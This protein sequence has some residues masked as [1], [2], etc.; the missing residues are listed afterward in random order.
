MSA[1]IIKYLVA[2]AVIALMIW[3]GSHL[4]FKPLNV[5]APLKGEA[6]HNPYYAAIKL[7]EELDA[8]ASW[9][10]VFVAPASDS[11]IVLS[12]WSWTMSRPRR[13]R[14]ERW[15]ESGGRLV[16]DDSLVSDEQTFEKWSGISELQKDKVESETE[17]EPASNDNSLASRFLNRKCSRLSEDVT[18]REFRVCDVNP[19]RSLTSSRK[20]LWALRAGN[21]IHALRTRVG[22]GSVTVLNASPFRFRDLFLGDHAQLLVAATQL[23]S[24]DEVMFLTEQDQASLL[25][26]VL[27]YGTPVVLLFALAIALA[28]WRVSARLGPLVAPLDAARRSLAEQ[29]RG[30]GQFAVRFGGG[31]ALHAATVRALRDAALRYFPAYD[32]LSSVDRVAALAKATGVPG[33]DLAPALN[34]QGLRGAAELRTAIAVLETTR[35]RILKKNKGSRNGN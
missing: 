24:G 19:A 29:I 30:T 9:E 33:D 8:E 18:H 28:I 14:M 34:V 10:R 4:R 16:V 27:R 11:V 13:E 22:V 31:A 20:I 15:V 6:A 12:D 17:D 5:D 2:G 25:T 26:L 23:H 1:R 21:R 7:S 32:H 3:I 35:R